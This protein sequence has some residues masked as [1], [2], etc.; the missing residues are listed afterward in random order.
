MVSLTLRS[1]R[2]PSLQQHHPIDE[3]QQ[4]ADLEDCHHQVPIDNERG[5]IS[6]QS[7]AIFLGGVPPSN[8]GSAVFVADDDANARTKSH[9]RSATTTSGNGRVGAAIL[10]HHI[11]HRSASI[12]Y[13]MAVLSHL[14]VASV[15]WWSTSQVY[16]SQYH[17]R[18]GGLFDVASS[19]D[20]GS[21]DQPQC[22]SEI[23]SFM[24]W[25]SNNM[26]IQRKH[27]FDQILLLQQERSVPK[28]VKPVPEKFRKTFYY[29][30]SKMSMPIARA[31][32][33]RGWRQVDDERHA[34]IIYTY[35]NNADWAERLHKW[36]RFNYIPGYHK[37]NGKYDFALYYKQWENRTGRTAMFV[38][39]TYMLSAN[40]AD[41]LAFQRR[42]QGGGG[43]K[44][45]W[46]LKKSNVNQGKGITIIAPNSEELFAIPELV[47]RQ[48]EDNSLDGN[49]DKQDQV[50]MQVENPS[51][52][53][54]E[55]GRGHKH[56]P[57]IESDMI[58]Q[59]YVCN[60]MT[61]GRRKF[62]VRMYWFVASLDPLIVL[63]HDGY[64][65]I[66]NSEY[67]E[68]DFTDTTA[69]LT[70]HTGLGAESKAT[71]REFQDAIEL[72][73]QQNADRVAQETN[74]STFSTRSSFPVGSPVDH[75][76]NQFKH[77]LAE[78]VEVFKAESFN[79]PD[80]S[81]LT[82][83]NGFNFYCAD[84]IL[85]NDLDVWFLEP[86]NGCGLDE[87]YYFRL[88]MHASLFNGMVDVLEEVWKKQ[89]G[90][91]PLLPLEK[92]GNWEVIY[93]DDIMYY[94]EGYERGLDKPGCRS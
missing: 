14:L 68:Q 24:N 57:L 90:G 45:P 38:P 28:K 16:D 73:H 60:E 86:Q 74:T 62:D 42:L 82:A 23:V 11:L 50:M 10:H 78:M 37:W 93:A 17:E 8:T 51:N 44:Y 13:L 43:E 12:L 3:Q 6:S 31:F 46:V 91:M 21:T 39:E 69:H 67:S 84:F 35:S 88:E 1:R 41:A 66:G 15:V 94:Y 49:S 59:K 22:P 63:Y 27:T 56:G 72:L 33:S 85:D 34:H 26:P 75:V 79:K 5:L 29:D 70:T 4:Q 92:T 47:L 58:I 64:V 76:R 81:E 65:R 20:A 77:A 80:F 2:H 55:A 87:D 61:W 30:G 52:S 32:R 71:F 40:E 36:Q 9:H 48:R 89:E 7:D 54:D 25:A 19:R 83:E 53:V 18:D